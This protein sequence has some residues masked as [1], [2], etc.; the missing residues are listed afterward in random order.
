[1]VQWLGRGYLMMFKRRGRGSIPRLG[2][3]IFF[4]FLGLG[5]VESLMRC[6]GVKVTHGNQI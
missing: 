3:L 5:W 2:N 4:L 1:M 6:K